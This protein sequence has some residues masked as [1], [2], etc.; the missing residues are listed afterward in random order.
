VRR[1]DETNA[2]ANITGGAFYLLLFEDTVI[3]ALTLRLAAGALACPYWNIA[4]ALD[5]KR[6]G[7]KCKRD[8]RLQRLVGLSLSFL[9]VL[10]PDFLRFF[11]EG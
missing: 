4:H 7:Q 2:L 8:C 11:M 3:S 10:F 5:L 1:L 9:F 6:K